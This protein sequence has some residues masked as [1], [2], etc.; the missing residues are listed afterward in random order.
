MSIKTRKSN[1]IKFGI[2]AT[3]SQANQV[4]ERR[5][6]DPQ[7][8]DSKFYT[9]KLNRRKEGQRTWLAYCLTPR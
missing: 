4:C 5:A 9:I 3:E 6:E 2:Y 1:R 7:F 8:K